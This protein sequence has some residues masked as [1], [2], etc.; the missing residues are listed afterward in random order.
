MTR[1]AANIH[2]PRIWA[3]GIS[4][5]RELYRELSSS[6]DDAADIRILERGFDDALQAIS[7][8][9]VAQPDV[10]V[11]AGANGSYV[12]TRTDIPVVLVS[13]TGF[14]VMQALARAR[15]ESRKIALVMHGETPLEVQRFLSSFEIEVKT[16]SYITTQD[17]ETCV[18]D[19][20]DSGAE[21]IVG[22]GLVTE[23]ADKA[24]MRS[25][26]LYSLGSV[27][28]AFDNALEL[29][30]AVR[31]EGVRRRRLDQ[32]LENLRDGVVALDATGR[33]EAVSGKMASILG[34]PA[35]QAVGKMLVELSREAALA[36]PRT[37]GESLETVNG[38]SYVV[39]RRAWDEAGQVPGAVVT[40]LESLA[41]QRMDRSLRSKQRASQFVARYRIS[42]LLG[43]SQVIARIRERVVQ[44]ATT[45]ATALITGATGTG[46][47]IVAQSIHNLSAR[48]QQPFIALNCGAFPD[49]LLESELFGYE[50]GAFT[51]AR[52]G[53]K[54]GLIEA[55]HQGTLFL[56]EI[57]EMPLALQSR[58]LRVIQE[59][60][61][62][63]LGSTEPVK[64]DV[65]IIAA[66]HGALKARV[67]EGSFRADLFYR[68]NVLTIVMPALSD[69]PADIP[70]LARHLLQLTR[71]DWSPADIEASLDA[72]LGLFAAYTW[73]GNVRELQ[74]VIERLSM[75][76]SIPG[77]SISPDHVI[78]VVPEMKALAQP[79]SLKGLG[80]QHEIEKVRTVFASFG[81]DR[82]KTCEALGISRTTLWRKLN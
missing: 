48:A 11:S 22:P 5:L 50:E 18:L 31:A 63:R 65:R 58:L 17:A 26:F 16:M 54:T 66:T 43:Q 69:R 70:L 40:F 45:D 20:R 60:E 53:G 67:D 77:H 47:E 32:V 15:R 35:S 29:A 59:R 57:A 51:G 23:L 1:E 7:A 81:G 52:R 42:D 34:V 46:K 41:L 13:A 56:D 21:I 39:H 30:R 33:I 12:K 25:V 10:I 73:P 62:V 4:R 49:T 19:L 44:Y 27:Q 55:A 24:G 2:R 28:A 36:V 80:L 68:I 37:S 64:V 14:D 3:V 8:A 38:V 6:Y 74:N 9:G 72:V 75:D 61:V 71:P 82:D 76:L 78:D 79:Q